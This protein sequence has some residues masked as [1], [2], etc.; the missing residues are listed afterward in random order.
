MSKIFNLLGLAVLG[1]ALL[2]GSAAAEDMALTGDVHSSVEVVLSPLTAISWASIVVGENT[3]DAA[4]TS[5]TVN[6]NI[7]IFENATLSVKETGAGDNVAD[8]KMYSPT[9]TH[10]LTN[11]L[12]LDPTTV[13]TERTL[14]A[15]DQEFF[16]LMLAGTQLVDFNFK[17]TVAYTDPAATDYAAVVTFTG[18]IV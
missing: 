17:Q 4:A 12:V 7:G 2:V 16:R 11:A 1:I 15:V 18:G 3:Y 5:A 6:S 13:G 9:T 8:G 14:S 10:A